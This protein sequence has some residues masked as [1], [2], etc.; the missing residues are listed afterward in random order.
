MAQLD[1]PP[2]V[3]RQRS[4]RRWLPVVLAVVLVLSLWALL[5]LVYVVTGADNDYATQ[6]DVIIV[7]GC[8]TIGPDSGPTVCISARS[9]HAADL[10]K[11]GIAPAIIATGGPT[12]GAA[13]E[14]EVL[15]S[16]LE[17]DGVP[18]DAIIQENRALN[19][20]QNLNYSQ[21]IMREHGWT[22]AVLVTEPFRIKRATLIA[23]D[24]GM[25]VYPSPAV[26][27][28][29]WQNIVLRAYNVARDT[30][31]LMWYQVKSVLGLRD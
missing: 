30:L 16:V 27:S 20:I 5:D 2:V 28:S 22:R 1:T 3:G 15:T 13:T 29:N 9:A 6:A 25:A 7:L 10:Y 21:A 12:G 23:R 4:R 24:S 14:A 26:N 17:S 18:T 11:K 19:T 31:S 8:N